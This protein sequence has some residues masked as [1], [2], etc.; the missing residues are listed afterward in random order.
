[1]ERQ[2]LT[3]VVDIVE[4]DADL[5]LVLA[6]QQAQRVEHLIAIGQ[7][8]L[9]CKALPSDAGDTQ[10]LECRPALILPDAGTTA[11]RI[12]RIHLLVAPRKLKSCLVHPIRSQ[13][14]SL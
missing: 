8:W 2:R 7:P 4:V 11:I 12:K 14:R 6:T 3:R 5:H 1:M 13:D 10:D 9:R